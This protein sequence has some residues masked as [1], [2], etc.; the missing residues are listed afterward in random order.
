M[1]P[2][3]FLR[4]ITYLNGAIDL[5]LLIQLL[6]YRLTRRY[7]WLFAYFLADILQILLL[8]RLPRRSVWY[9]NIYFGGQ[10]A[11]AILG[12]AFAITLWKLALL[13]YPALAR[14][15]RRILIYLLL[16]ATALAA[17]GLLL[18]PPA[19]RGQN[20]LVHS[21][22]AIEGAVDSMVMLFLSA[23]VLF[24]LWFPVKMR[25]NVAVWIG[26]FVFYWFQRWAGLLL[27]NFYPKYSVAL[28]I[29]AVALQLACLMVWIFTIR[30][31]GEIVTTVPGHRW[32]P[33]ETEHLLGQL[34]AINARLDKLARS[35]VL[36]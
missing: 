12:V 34:D 17:A 20:P 28:S 11:K 36:S 26:G 16:A 21:L 25:R 24:L 35:D 14:F 23:A 5:C 19:P 13:G 7:V 3:V 10:A 1:S 30:P 18:E 9:G 6:R 27:L 4:W 15:G 22:Q 8:I 32:N 29:S 2:A 33:A 31:E